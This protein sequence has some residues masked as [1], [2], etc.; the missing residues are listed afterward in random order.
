MPVVTADKA[1]P[2]VSYRGNPL[3]E[4]PPQEETFWLVVGT[5]PQLERRLAG[6]LHQLGV[7]YFLP[8][9]P[10]PV[11]TGGRILLGTRLLLPGYVFVGLANEPAQ[12]V[13]DKWAVLDTKRVR[14]L[15][16]VT[17]GMQ[18]QLHSELSTLLAATHHLQ[19]AEYARYT[20]GSRVRFRDGH[21]LGGRY[22]ILETGAKIPKS[23]STAPTPGVS[24]SR[25]RG[26][27]PS[28]VPRV[29]VSFTAGFE[30]LGV[31][32]FVTEVSNL[33]LH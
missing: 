1:P 8:M 13:S 25:V 10:Y 17:R 20:A 3:D 16:E 24:S 15:I 5:K 22:A 19:F 12:R 26:V 30:M 29:V 6:E 31:S 18:R 14:S 23:Y 11:K 33:E 7:P 27:A 28:D 32:R 9:Q 4:L 2:V 21:P